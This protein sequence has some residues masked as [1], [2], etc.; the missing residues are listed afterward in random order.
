MLG[1]EF[2]IKKSDVHYNPETQEVTMDREKFDRLVKYVADLVGQVETAE[3]SRDVARYRARR[4]EGIVELLAANVQ[5]GAAAITDWV[6]QN[7]VKQLSEQ[8]GIPYATCHRIVNARLEKSTVGLGQFLKMVKVVG[9]GKTT[10]TSAKKAAEPF[11]VMFDMRKEKVVPVMLDM[12]RKK[13]VLG[14]QEER[15]QAV[16]SARF[17]RAKLKQHTKLQEKSATAE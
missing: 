1:K 9:G 12:R 14:T 13:V 7:S 15:T 5:S 4:A 10:V 2:P 17:G 11:A 6:D 3:D 8:S 16:R